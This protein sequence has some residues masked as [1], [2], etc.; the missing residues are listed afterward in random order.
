[1]PNWTEEEDIRLV[2]YKAEGYHFK[3]IVDLFEKKRTFNACKSRLVNIGRA[4][5]WTDAS[6]ATLIELRNIK[7]L[8]WVDI[9]HVIGAPALTCEAKY[10]VKRRWSKLDVERLREY[11]SIQAHPFDIASHLGR[12]AYACKGKANSDSYS[13]IRWRSVDIKQWTAARDRQLV[14][15]A[16]D[17]VIITQNVKKVLKNAFALSDCIQR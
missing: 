3:T 8:S 10:L 1:M 12:T 11:M 6:I 17:S 16:L 14:F 5:P 7:G 4:W 2:K 9:A 13:S 15:A